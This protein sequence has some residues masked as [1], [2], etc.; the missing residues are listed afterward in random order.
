MNVRTL[1]DGVVHEPDDGVLS[2][3]MTRCLVHFTAW[4]YVSLVLERTV[5]HPT[6]DPVDCVLC[7]ARG[8]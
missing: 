6:E 7:L 5:A 4:S 8:R 3:G 1:D 2:H